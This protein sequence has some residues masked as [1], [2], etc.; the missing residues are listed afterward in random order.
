MSSVDWVRSR[1]LRRFYHQ[2]FLVFVPNSKLFRGKGP[3]GVSKRRSFLGLME[4]VCFF[5][6]FSSFGS[7]FRCPLIF[8]RWVEQKI[9][10]SR[11][12]YTFVLMRMLFNCFP[13]QNYIHCSAFQFF[14]TLWKKKVL[15]RTPQKGSV[16]VKKLL[17]ELKCRKKQLKKSTK[18]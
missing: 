12:F 17:D 18:P 15:S 7:F 5:Q 16:D 13:Y 1:G 6:D 10:F 8:F 3:I 4:F 2:A 11:E 14:H 9:V